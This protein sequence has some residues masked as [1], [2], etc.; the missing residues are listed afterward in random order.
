M[1]T[2][3]Y[4]TISILIFCFTAF[5]EEDVR[6]SQHIMV[7]SVFIYNF[8]KYIQ[9]PSD[10]SSGV[11][12]IGVYG[13]SNIV[14]ALKEIARKKT[15]S[16]RKIQIK[17]YQ[18]TNNID[19]CH[20]LFITQNEEKAIPDIL[21]RIKNKNILSV[22][23]VDNF[24]EHGGMINLIPIEGKIKFEINLASLK[25]AGLTAGSQ[26]LKL[27]ILVDVDK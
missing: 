13:E 11:F 5:A 10:D 18:H 12:I 19:K 4:I 2:I 8:T 26:L 27:A 24:S 1:K 21:D 20:I 17:Q 6:I 7:K 22:S 16:G 3:V 25:R 23:E 15:V 9:W 14:I